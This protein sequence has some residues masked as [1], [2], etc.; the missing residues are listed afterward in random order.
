MFENGCLL[1]NALFVDVIALSSRE[2]EIID[3]LMDEREF[4][5]TLSWYYAAGL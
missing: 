2:V 5:W 1:Q 4:Y 3:N